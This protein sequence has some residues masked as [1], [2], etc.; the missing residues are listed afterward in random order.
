[1]WPSAGLCISDTPPSDVSFSPLDDTGGFP[2]P[3]P[4]TDSGTYCV[5]AQAVPSDGGDTTMVQVRIATVPETVTATQ[6][7]VPPVERSPII[8]QII[9]DLEIPVPDRCADVIQKIESLTAADLVGGGV[10]VH[11]LPT[12][13]LA[14]NGTSQCAQTNGRTLESAA[15]AD[16]IKQL[17][18]TL[19]GKHQQAHLMYFN[20]LDAPLP[21]PLTTSIQSLLDALAQPPPGYEL[22]PQHWMFAPAAAFVG[23]ITWWAYW[24]WETTDDMFKMMLEDY[25]RQKLPY[26]SQ[27]HLAYEPVALLSP[28]DTTTYA[29]SW[30]KICSSSPGITPIA[31]M[32]FQRDITDPAWKITTDDPPSYLVTLNNQIAVAATQFVEQSAIVNYQICTKYCA[33]HPYVTAAGKPGY[34]WSEEYTC[35]TKDE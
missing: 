19:D 5:A 10:P 7:F 6:I 20:N 21:M 24:P 32:P 4:L 26:T 13:N 3:L 28:A 2:P 16:Q 29:G 9:L 15:M 8:Y 23:P 11:K 27:E 25:G 18:T 17:I 12:I 22:I 14:A 30:V 31:T 1:M 35:A 33:D 34:S